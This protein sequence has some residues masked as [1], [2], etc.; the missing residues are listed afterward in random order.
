MAQIDSEETAP[1]TTD[2]AATVRRTRR[3]RST[4]TAIQ[5]RNRRRRIVIGSSCVAVALL[6]WG[7]YVA[8]EA[9]QVKTNLE[10]ARDFATQAKDALLAGNSDTASVAARDAVTYAD[11]AQDATGSAGWR[12]AAAIP[13]LGG[14]LKTT[15][16]IADVVQGLTSDV[17]MPAVTTGAAMSPD[18]LIEAGARINLQPLRDAAPALADT[19]AAAAALAAQAQA[20]DS[21]FLGA[22]DTARI[23][24]QDQTAELSGLL[25][26]V[27]TAADIAPA[28]LG[29]DGP[30]SYF[31]GFQT[32][33]EARGTGGLLG[34]FGEFRAVDGTIR[35]EDLGSNKELSIDD[36]KPI[37]LGPDFEKQYGHSRPT[38]DFRNSNVSSHFPYA[39][40][41]WRSLWAQESGRQVDG[42]IATDPVALSYILAVVG[43]VTMPDGEKITADN[44]VELTEST[45]Y[46]RFANDNNARKAYLQTVAAKVVEKMTGKISNP[47][48][49][50]EALGRAASEG[51]IAVWSANPAEQAV[52]EGT[53]LGHTVPDDPAPYAGVVVNNLGG[54]KLDY[55]LEREI[56]YTAGSCEA[57]TRT[58]QVT[59][60]L[61]NTLPPGDYTKYVAGMF[62]NPMGAPIGTN[63]TNLS[64]VATQGAKLNKVTVDGKPA[65]AF[66]GAE[67]GHPVF[68]LQTQ[69]RQGKTVEV[70]YELTEP[71][72]A[73]EA[74]VPVQALVGAVPLDVQVTTCSQ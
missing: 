47:Q 6:A 71:T 5:A 24:L 15:G 42:A 43:P 59:V 4:Q 45:A 62:D 18:Q 41:I 36:K 31:I 22:V 58:S 27:S 19:A 65:F 46:A 55:Y 54:N 12:L 17:L 69:I 64:L 23:Q 56:E 13:G 70:K 49:L 29:A 25:G 35:L 72:V 44:V 14:P 1:T 74:R 28:M 16:Q 33:A 67:R 39:A 3:R 63:L 50:L 52:L 30:R 53:A 9:T 20:V 37:D 48:G 8:Y 7:G 61:T 26:N 51:R 73:G 2:G 21:S 57:D 32:N 66:T 11:R 10:R 40:Q 60:R 34:G 38:T 68:D